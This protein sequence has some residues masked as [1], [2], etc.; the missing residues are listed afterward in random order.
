ME[1]SEVWIWYASERL[2]PRARTAEPR[3]ISPWKG[4]ELMFGWHPVLQPYADF[5]KAVSYDTSFD[6]EADNALCGLARSDSFATWNRLTAGAWR[7]LWERLAYAEAVMLANEVAGERVITHLPR[8]LD[9]Q[10]RSRAL[11]LQFLLGG[12]KTIDRRLLASTA[13]GALP[14][15]PAST[16]SRRH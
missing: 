11:G 3:P 2:G 5:A 16:S 10:S 6:E 13:P 14:T 12:A 1:L 8:G 4:V 7:V 15:L 9:W